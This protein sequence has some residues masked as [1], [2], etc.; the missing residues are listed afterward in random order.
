MTQE[1]KPDYIFFGADG[2]PKRYWLTRDSVITKTFCWAA[3]SQVEADEGRFTCLELHKCQPYSDGL[4]AACENYLARRKQAE[5]DFRTEF[6]NLKK[7]QFGMMFGPFSVATSLN[8]PDGEIHVYNA[9]SQA[10]KV[11]NLGAE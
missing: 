3:S 6:A 4:W 2:T 10:I 5:V 11:I 9:G 1:R 7:G 8:V